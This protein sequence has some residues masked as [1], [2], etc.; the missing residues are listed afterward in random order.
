MAVGTVKFFNTSKGFGF[1]QQV[2][3]KDHFGVANPEHEF[4]HT[5]IHHFVLPH[6]RSGG[7]EGIV[8]DGIKLNGILPSAWLRTP[9]KLRANVFARSSGMLSSVVHPSVS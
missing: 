5:V 6:F 3:L 7:G 4:I 9:T 2:Q 8:L 1:I